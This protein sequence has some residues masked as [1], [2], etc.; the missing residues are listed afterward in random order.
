M[1]PSDAATQAE[2]LL[3]RVQAGHVICPRCHHDNG[4]VKFEECAQD[5]RG[6]WIRCAGCGRAIRLIRQPEAVKPRS[7]P[8][9]NKKE[10]LRRRWAGR[11]GERF[12]EG[13]GG[14]ALNR[15]EVSN[16]E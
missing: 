7:R 4:K 16:G 8:S 12:P 11:E 1:N 10:R 3:K 2:D 15:S 5:R 6:A 14:Q 9:G 13:R